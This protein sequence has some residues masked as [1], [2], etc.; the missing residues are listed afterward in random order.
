LAA[1]GRVSLRGSEISLGGA[2]ARL[3][4]R[5]GVRQ[6]ALRPGLVSIS[7]QMSGKQ[8][9][10]TAVEVTR[11]RARRKYSHFPSGA[12]RRASFVPGTLNRQ[13]GGSIGTRTKPAPPVRP[14]ALQPWW[15]GDAAYVGANEHWE[16]GPPTA[17]T[18]STRANY[19]GRTSTNKFV[20]LGRPAG[21]DFRDLARLGTGTASR[22]PTAF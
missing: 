7:R 17:P 13:K 20:G 15:N 21:F 19:G 6:L 12:L 1:E 10:A 22:C 4:P 8:V 18:I 11:S 14:R 3:A 9:P 16:S 2:A 5:F